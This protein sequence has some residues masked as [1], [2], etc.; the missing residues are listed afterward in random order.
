MA[1]TQPGNPHKKDIHKMNTRPE[2]QEAK[3]IQR[4]N[5]ETKHVEKEDST[6]T[7]TLTAMD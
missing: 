6:R 3:V 7:T 5:Q 4:A 2:D 1:K